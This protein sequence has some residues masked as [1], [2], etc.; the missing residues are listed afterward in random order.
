MKKYS[1]LFLLL[2]ASSLLT[3][4]EAINTI[5]KAGMWWAFILM[6]LVVVAVI[7]IISKIFGGGKK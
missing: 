2:A 7:W 6:F 3:S 4:C 5:F 1:F